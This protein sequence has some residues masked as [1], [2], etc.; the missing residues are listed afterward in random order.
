MRL[1]TNEV[2]YEVN[3]MQYKTKFSVSLKLGHVHVAPTVN[4]LAIN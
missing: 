4:L 2:T 3:M 1:L